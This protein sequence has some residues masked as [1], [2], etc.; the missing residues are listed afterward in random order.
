MKQILLI[1]S[2]V[3]LYLISCKKDN[4]SAHE[5]E[6][7]T[8]TDETGESI[9]NTDTTDWRTDDVFTTQ[10]KELFDTIN[11]QSAGNLKNTFSSSENPI[12]KIVFYPNP[13]FTYGLFNFGSEN[14]IINLVIVDKDFNIILNHRAI[15]SNTLEF[16]FENL[17]PA[18]YRAYYVIQDLHFKIVGMGHGDIQKD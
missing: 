1:I 12:I 14:V 9:G 5:F 2:L 6:G 18:I 8:M 10:E 16:D 4:D 17:N 3:C 13:T 15:N 11:F 7:I